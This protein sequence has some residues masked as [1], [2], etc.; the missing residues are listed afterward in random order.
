M[1]KLTKKFRTF[2]PF[3][4]EAH[5]DKTNKLLHFIGATLFFICL[6]LSI[7]TLNIIYFICGIFIGYILPHIGHKH[8]Q[9]NSSLRNS[10]PVF[11]VLGAFALY[12]KIWKTLF[13]SK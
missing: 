7:A 3:Y 12:L 5:S 11:C 8:Y 9:G 4:F 1:I 6:G 13:F 2:L 10:H